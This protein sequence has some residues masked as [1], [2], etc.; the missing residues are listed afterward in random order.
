MAGP[1]ALYCW[2]GVWWRDRAWG[3]RELSAPVSISEGKHACMT[4]SRSRRST[5]RTPRQEQQQQQQQQAK[6]S[7]KE[8]VVISP[9]AGAFMGLPAINRGARRKR[10]I[11]NGGYS[12]VGLT[13]SL[14][15]EDVSVR[16]KGVKCIVLCTGGHSK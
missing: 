9:L 6:V 8:Y 13:I 7:K 14:A 3:D 2:G 12:C 15:M 11:L 10:L 5:T 16:M 1:R 4:T